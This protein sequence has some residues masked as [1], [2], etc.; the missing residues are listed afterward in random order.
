V[1]FVRA[2]G[3]NAFVAA[4][5]GQIINWIRDPAKYK[6]NQYTQLVRSEQ[7]VGVYYRLHADDSVRVVTDEEHA[8]ADGDS[9][10]QK[11][12]NA[13]G[14]RFDTVEFVCKRR[15][16]GSKIGW[17]ALESGKRD[18]LNLLIANT[19]GV[20]N[21]LMI[22]RTQRVVTMLENAANWPASSVGTAT[23]LG[24]G[25]WSAGSDTAPFVKKTLLQVATNIHLS[26]NGMASDLDNE[27]DVGL[28]LVLSPAAATTISSSP[29][30]HAYLSRSP[31]ALQQVVGGKRGQNALWGLPEYLYGFKVV[32]EN[33]VRV[34]ARANADGTE[35]ATAARA[36]VKALNS[37]LVV[38]RPGGL[39]GQI[40]APSF[41]TA[42]I[43]YYNKELSVE[44]FD[45]AEDEL[46]RV[47][48]QENVTEVIAAA[49][50]GF[51]ITNLF[52]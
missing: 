4:A 30:I 42:Q 14:Q 48:A 51:L 3:F 34:S 52:S 45:D 8:W 32:V 27:E 44:T 15:N 38:S 22:N 20:Q 7:P 21:E 18:Q 40:G 9:R 35:D 49:R 43:Y 26:T 13:E 10:R 25:F 5:T 1:A 36:W 12:S 28:N 17:Q 24:G 29:E 11:L 31:F 16:Y 37:A 2:S 41:S 50:A 19:K 46:T 39:E 23:A 6:V 33:A 47:Y